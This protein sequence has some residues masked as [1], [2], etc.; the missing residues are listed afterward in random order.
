[1]LARQ[2]AAHLEP[3]GPAGD[4]LRQAADFVVSRRT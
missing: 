2:A 1:M 3:F 4:L